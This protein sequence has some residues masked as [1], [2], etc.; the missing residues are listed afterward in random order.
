MAYLLY[1]L[2]KFEKCLCVC[3]SANSSAIYGPMGTKLGREVP[4]E[5]DSWAASN[6]HTIRWQS[7]GTREIQGGNPIGK[8]LVK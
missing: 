6:H 8:A 4:M 5:F 7:A 2:L 3:L 1:I